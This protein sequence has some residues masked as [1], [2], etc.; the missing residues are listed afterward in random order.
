MCVCVCVYVCVCVCV[1]V[2]TC[3][4]TYIHV[5]MCV[6]CVHFPLAS[7]VLYMH[8]EP[9]KSVHLSFAGKVCS[10]FVLRSSTTIG[11]SG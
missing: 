4:R 8:N 7:H 6:A 9:L 11:L 1:C 5:Y 10:N 3:V 2:C